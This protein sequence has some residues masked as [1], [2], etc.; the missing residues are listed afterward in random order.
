MDPTLIAVL[1]T[2]AGTV[3]GA[4][5]AWLNTRQQLNHQDRTR[6]SAEQRDLVSKLLVAYDQAADLMTRTNDVD[7]IWRLLWVFHG[8]VTEA[9]L[10]VPQ[11]VLERARSMGEAFDAFYDAFILRV[12]IGLPPEGHPDVPGEKYAS[13]HEA[14][15]VVDERRRLLSDEARR[16]FGLRN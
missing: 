4:A 15:A 9:E 7:E 10:V 11:T 13:E 6:W 3:L 8:G 14:K 2:L 1:G 16:V 5:G 12:R